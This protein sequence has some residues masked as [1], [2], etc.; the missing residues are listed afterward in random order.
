MTFRV[1]QFPAEES[2]R[3]IRMKRIPESWM[4]SYTYRG[5]SGFLSSWLDDSNDVDPGPGHINWGAIA[6]LGL[7]VA[8]SAGFWVAVALLIE[9]LAR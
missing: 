8:I 6:G 9:R 4:G 3:V 5:D 2:T 1:L 7:S